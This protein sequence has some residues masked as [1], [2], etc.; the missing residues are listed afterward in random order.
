M[1]V[2][3]LVV[4]AGGQATLE[5]ELTDGK[6]NRLSNITRGTVAC[7][8][9]KKSTARNNH[10]VTQL[11][12]VLDAENAVVTLDLNE[13]QTASL[14]PSIT[15]TKQAL[16]QP[17][18]GDIVIRGVDYYG[19]FGFDV[20][21]P[22][23]Y[24]GQPSPG[25]T[26]ADVRDIIRDS[27]EIIA[28]A[29]DAYFGSDDWAGGAEPAPEWRQ[30]T[31]WADTD[32]DGDDSALQTLLQSDAAN[33]AVGATIPLADYTGTLNEA[34][35]VLAREAD[36]GNPDQIYLYPT[37][38]GGFAFNVRPQYTTEPATISINGRDMLVMVAN[39]P[40]FVISGGTQT[41]HWSNP[42]S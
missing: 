5:F 30:Y 24:T 36:A 17:C 18:V 31:A 1:I 12:G 41:I 40:R 15:D 42:L 2:L 32:I 6:G 14:A 39:T 13:A 28:N 38:G 23:T 16:V 7:S 4:T 11:V 22:E 26:N 37:A 27:G 3:P 29:L 33:T 25:L 8:L 9:R 35:I 21:M 19:P 10:E 34:Y 20:R